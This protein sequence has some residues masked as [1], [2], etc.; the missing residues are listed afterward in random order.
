MTNHI[1][2]ISLRK[3]ARVAGLWYLLM[4]I[5]GPIGLLIVPSKIIVAGNPA[6]TAQ[7]IVANELLFSVGILSN[8]LCQISFIFLVLALDRLFKGVDDKQ[9]KLMVSLVIAA[10]PIALLNELTQ[11]AALHLLSGAE[12]LKV[13][14]P[15]QL[16]ALVM[17]FLNLHEQGI[18]IVGIFWGL[19]LFPFGFLII[20]SGFIPKIFGILLI[21]NCFAYLTDSFN[22][23]FISQYREI[24]SPF[25]MLPM[26]AGEIS[27]LLWLLIKG[28]KNQK[29][30]SIE[31]G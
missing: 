11:I 21:I 12:Y 7:N 2:D 20:K 23:L 24:I 30:A 19:W 14:K 3:A 29:P 31:A 8:I 18:I 16:N 27:T 5:T 4:A 25:L 17:I 22:A 6:V 26:V 9:V 1:T 13:F 15:D 28:V 10:V